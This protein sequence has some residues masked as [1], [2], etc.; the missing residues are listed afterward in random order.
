M[1]KFG[2][3]CALT[4]TLC[5]RKCAHIPHCR[6]RSNGNEVARRG[7]RRYE[8]A[9]QSDTEV[10][11]VENELQLKHFMVANLKLQNGSYFVQRF[12]NIRQKCVH[13]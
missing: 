8:V 9:L 12:A 11:C 1:E 3:F 2:V 6:C 10:R 4:L 13:R 5:L 7:K